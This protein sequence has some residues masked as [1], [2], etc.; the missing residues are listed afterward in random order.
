MKRILREPLLH[1]VLIGAAIFA[2]HAAL[3]GRD[4]GRKRVVVTKAR[5]ESLA[6]AFSLTWQRPPTPAELDGL[7]RDYVR[8]EIAVRE[9]ASLGLAQDDVVI[10]RRL[11][12]KLVLDTEADAARAEPTDEELRAWLAAHPQDFAAAGRMPPFE[13]VRD[14]VRREWAGAR[15]DS[16]VERLYGKLLAGYTVTIE[17]PESLS[18]AAVAGADTTA[19]TPPP[20]RR[21]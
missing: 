16:A 18:G 19:K 21:D 3:S 12:Q 14:A 1:F 10:R 8:E 20:E 13:E 4:A 11:R 7:I 5:V 2:L 17:T 9:A 6:A 15:R